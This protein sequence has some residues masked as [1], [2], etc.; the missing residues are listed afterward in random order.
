MTPK[1]VMMFM[2]A[3]PRPS[4]GEDG[5]LITTIRRLYTQD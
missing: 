5:L 4:L 2:L 1:M 3:L